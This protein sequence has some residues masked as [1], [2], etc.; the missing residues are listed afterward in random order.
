MLDRGEVKHSSS[1]SV[2]SRIQCNVV[3]TENCTFSFA[4]CSLSQSHDINFA[5]GKPNLS[6]CQHSWN[7]R[8]TVHSKTGN[9]I[10][11][12]YHEARFNSVQSPLS[13]YSPRETF[14]TCNSPTWRL[15]LIYATVKRIHSRVVSVALLG[16][17]I[18]GSGNP[19]TKLS[20]ANCSQCVSILAYALLISLPGQRG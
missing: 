10:I 9:L 11:Y 18:S 14:L 2:V 4:V 7:R 12:K 17:Q 3:K 16:V 15:A 5:S 13:H 6:I 8:E 1:S 20:R 19:R